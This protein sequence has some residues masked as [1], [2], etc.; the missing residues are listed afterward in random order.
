MDYKPMHLQNPWDS[1]R[2]FVRKKAEV[3][4]AVDL[5]SSIVANDSAITV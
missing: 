5:E 1:A 3:T 2:L 4:A